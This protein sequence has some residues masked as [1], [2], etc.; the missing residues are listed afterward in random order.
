MA[1]AIVR[2]A[3]EKSLTLE[4]AE[5]FESSSGIGVHGQVGSRRL[6]L[7]NSTL[8]AQENIDLSPLVAQ[9]ETLRRSGMSLVKLQ[10][11]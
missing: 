3:K 11:S 2:A 4:K 1:E 8:M 9:A 6:S 5:G 7:G 10:R